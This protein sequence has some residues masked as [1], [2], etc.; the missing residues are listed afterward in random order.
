MVI[1][2]AVILSRLTH[3]TDKPIRQKPGE[4]DDGDGQEGREEGK[5]KQ[6]RKS[7]RNDLTRKHARNARR[8]S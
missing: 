4:E 5:E 2:H 6:G 3:Q 1:F 7:F 8:H